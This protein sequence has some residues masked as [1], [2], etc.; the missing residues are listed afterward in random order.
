MRTSN[1]GQS[2]TRRG[3]VLLRLPRT[4]PSFVATLVEPS[5]LWWIF[6]RTISAL[7]GGAEP[8]RLATGSPPAR[9]PR[10][11]SKAGMN[12][13]ALALVATVA[14]VAVNGPMVAQDRAPDSSSGQIGTVPGWS[15]RWPI[16]P[17][18]EALKAKGPDERKL[19]AYYD[20]RSPLG[21]PLN[22]LSHMFACGSEMPRPPPGEEIIRPDYATFLKAVA[23]KYDAIAVGSAALRR[24]L[25]N[26][27]ES[28]L[29]SEYTVSVEQW[30][31]P[32]A[33]ERLV[34]ASRAGGNVRLADGSAL[35]IEFN[36]SGEPDGRRIFML[37][38]IVGT[39]GFR[40]TQSL[41]I[42]AGYVQ[43]RFAEIDFGYLPD[44]LLTSEPL[45]AV[46]FL[47]DLSVAGVRCSSLGR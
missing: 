11:V 15:T 30:I 10:P 43:P 5:V 26:D 29:I 2:G 41:P 18:R 45:D 31:R 13:R 42:H 1:S 19:A 35:G 14:L 47:R 25:L 6:L 9:Q 33:R 27:P 24:V 28:A 17:D 4:P 39:S 7:A 21:E 20:W 46:R 12:A 8:E 36:G 32:A 40:I 37:T 34:S 22:G 44:E 23:C 38:R 3:R 16:V